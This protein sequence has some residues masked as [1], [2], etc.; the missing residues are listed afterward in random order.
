LD[1]I[2]RNDEKAFNDNIKET[3]SVMLSDKTPVDLI[4]HGSDIAVKIN[5]K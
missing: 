2:A 5:K 3:F 1:F 4:E